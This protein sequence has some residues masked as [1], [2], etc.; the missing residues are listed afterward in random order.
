MKP[1]I[2]NFLN[3]L[4]LIILGTWGYFASDN[5]SFTALIPVVFGVILIMLTNGIR[6]ENKVIAHLAVI[7]TLLIFIG[8]IK[9]ITGAL[10]REDMSA[11]IRVIAMMTTSIIAMILF[12][13]S[14]RD[15]RKAREQR[16]SIG[17]SD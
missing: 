3:A 2:A 9:P 13:K 10:A 1:H 17:S 6:K 14:F 15:A 16:D 7:L 11:V 5:P 8:L 4:V 12:I